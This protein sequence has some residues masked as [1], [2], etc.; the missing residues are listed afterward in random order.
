M[1]EQ[2][3]VRQPKTKRCEQARCGWCGDD[4]LYQDYH[5]REWGVPCYD[6]DKLFEFLLLEGAQKGGL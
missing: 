3:K 5:D 6:D 4:P 2:L 1:T